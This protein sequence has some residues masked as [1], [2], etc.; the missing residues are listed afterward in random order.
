MGDLE[1]QCVVEDHGEEEWE[2]APVIEVHRL[3]GVALLLCQTEEAQLPALGPQQ[4]V[5]KGCSPLQPCPT[6]RALLHHSPK[7]KA[8]RNM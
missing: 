7:L 2:G 8:M 4:E 3:A 1:E 5:L 6:S